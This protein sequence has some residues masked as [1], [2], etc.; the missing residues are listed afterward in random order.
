MSVDLELRLAN[1]SREALARDGISDRACVM[2]LFAML[3]EDIGY[4]DALKVWARYENGGCWS[5][6]RWHSEIC[7]QL[8][9]AWIT[10][11]PGLYFDR[12]AEEVLASAH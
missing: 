2:V 6:Q 10:E 5:A 12:K 8:L 7:Y 3:N 11:S 9:K 1:A 4:E